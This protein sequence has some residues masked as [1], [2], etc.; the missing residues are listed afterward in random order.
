MESSC[1][2]VD[3]RADDLSGR[4]RDARGPYYIF[5][6]KAFTTDGFILTAGYS[7]DVSSLQYSAGDMFT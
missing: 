1:A 6:A 3:D 4:M 2:S 5:I 7:P